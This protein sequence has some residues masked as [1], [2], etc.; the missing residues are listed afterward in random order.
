[1][2]PPT[3]DSSAGLNDDDDI[4]NALALMHV[5]NEEHLKKLDE[6]RLDDVLKARQHLR[7]QEAR[8]TEIRKFTAET[9]I[10]RL[11]FA[12]DERKRANEESN[13]RQKQEHE[14][15]L[16]KLK[17][18]YI[19]NVRQRELNL[20]LAA[21]ETIKLKLESDQKKEDI[22]KV[23]LESRKLQ[24]ADNRHARKYREREKKASM[25]VYKLNADDEIMRQDLDE[26][27]IAAKEKQEQLSELRDQLEQLERQRRE[28]EEQNVRSLRNLSLA[29]TG[30]AASY[31]AIGGVLGTTAAVG[32]TAAGLAGAAAV[33]VPL[34][35]T[36]AF[37]SAVGYVY[38][39]AKSSDRA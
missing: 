34:S 14:K 23:K 11:Q 6:K 31:G 37:V 13:Q 9:E 16:M 7:E 28:E 4:S 29:A 5:K 27:R 20:K 10:M 8:A 2:Q 19:N 1:M 3:P 36:V 26:R 17:I 15:E 39:K 21:Q 24:C 35:S 33:L 22:E 12:E 32:I 18:D 25:E 38:K 30:V